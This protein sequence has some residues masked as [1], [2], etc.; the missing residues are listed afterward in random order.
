VQ[1]L[2]L[3]VSLLTAIGCGS[4]GP[5]S[6][7][8]A[9]T[10][11]A[12]VSATDGWTDREVSAQ[13]APPVALPGDIVVVR[14]A[15]YLPREQVFDGTP[16]ALWPGEDASTSQLVYGW[17]FDDG[18]TRLVRWER[19]FTVSLDGPLA[20]DAEVE[21]AVESALSEIG[22]LTG[23]PGVVV[24]S[25]GEVTIAVDPSLAQDGVVGHA[26]IDTRGSAIV[27]ARVRLIGRGEFFG[28]GRS[29]S[30]HTLLHELGHVAGLWHSAS[31]ADVMHPGGVPAA[32][33][34]RSFSAAEQTAL[35]MMYA[36]RRPGN[37]PVDRE[38]GAEASRSSVAASS[39]LD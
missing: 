27:S 36:H 21:A 29:Q 23:I 20:G 9:T 28:D 2:L 31:G 5:T 11:P 24:G 37:L 3:V 16:I 25:G 22:R 14:A 30:P 1:R 13:I 4:A 19:P 10:A 35:H 18:R 32:R 7:G 34:P 12:P 26:H 38:P 8:A 33:Q 15:G 6:P 17:T 39:V